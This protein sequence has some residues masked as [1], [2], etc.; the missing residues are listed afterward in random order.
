MTADPGAPPVAPADGV[1]SRAGARA[2]RGTRREE[3]DLAY[4]AENPL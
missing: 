3:D 4:F 2:D 1:S